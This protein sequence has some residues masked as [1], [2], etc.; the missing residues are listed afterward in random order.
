VPAGKVK[1]NGKCVRKKIVVKKAKKVKKPPKTCYLNGRPVS[2]CV[3][4]KG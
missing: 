3:R 2:P 4:G 1:T